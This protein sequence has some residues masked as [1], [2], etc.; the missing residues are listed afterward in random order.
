MIADGLYQW[1]D[2]YPSEEILFSD[3]NDGNMIVAIEDGA[4]AG[5]VTVNEDIPQEYKEINLLFSPKICVHRLSVNP[6]HARRG[7]A[8]ALMEYVH[9]SFKNQGYKSIC[10][11]TCEDNIAAISLYNK[12]KY[13]KRGY[14][15]FERRPKL[16][17]PV[18]ERKL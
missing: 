5:Y 2:E 15:S 7:T 14:V 9:D 4:I 16:R 13:V 18:M 8:K 1:D 17:F 3:I 12:L 6:A 10:L 11:D